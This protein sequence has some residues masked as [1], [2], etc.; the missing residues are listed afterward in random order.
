MKPSGATLIALFQRN[1]ESAYP[2]LRSLADSGNADA[3]YYLGK[4]YL[5]GDYVP[6]SDNY[7]FFLI[8]RSALQRHKEAQ[9]LVSELY[10]EGAGC[11]QSNR[12]AM[13][14]LTKAAKQG[15]P[16][17]AI[18]LAEHYMN[19]IFVKRNYRIAMYWLHSNRPT[20]SLLTRTMLKEPIE[21]EEEVREHK[22]NVMVHKLRISFIYWQAKRVIFKKKLH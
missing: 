15:C 18:R 1:F 14:F 19:G 5:L 7:A 6:Q 22:R 2:E 13:L 8:K 12:K 16:D 10:L 11:T 17:A 4:M 9:A 3:C 20:R 21:P